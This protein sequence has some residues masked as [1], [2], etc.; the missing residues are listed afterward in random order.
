MLDVSVAYNRYKFLG[1][2]FLTW[3][4]FM[5]ETDKEALLKAD[6]ELEDMYIGNRIALEN[7]SHNRDEKITIKGD[8]AGLEEGVIALQKGAKVTEIHLVAK[9]KENEWQFNVKG[10]S[11]NIGNLKSPE[12]GRVEQAEDV[13]GAVLEKIYLYEKAVN[14]TNQLYQQFIKSRVSPDWENT[15]VKQISRWILKASKE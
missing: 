8:G 1:H 2:E 10:E 7:S 15:V 9:A 5:I 13:E 11:L 6:A 14:L 12:T 4:W 3:L